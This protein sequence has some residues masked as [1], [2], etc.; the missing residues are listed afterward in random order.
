[1]YEKMKATKMQTYIQRY[2]DSGAAFCCSPLPAAA[3]GGRKAL[4]PSRYEPTAS[5]EIALDQDGPC[6]AIRS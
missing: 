3:D 4:T 2:V 6:L 5:S 1:M